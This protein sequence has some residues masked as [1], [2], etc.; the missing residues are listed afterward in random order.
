M[1]V[2]VLACGFH[3]NREIR[4]RATVA[5]CT[6]EGGD[7][8]EVERAVVVDVGGDVADGFVDEHG[9]DIDD[10]SVVREVIV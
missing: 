9:I 3:L 5:E 8:E 1:L 10:A 7:I 2:G 4:L 6:Q